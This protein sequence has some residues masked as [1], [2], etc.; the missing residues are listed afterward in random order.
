MKL[1]AKVSSNAFLIFGKRFGSLRH[2]LNLV[3]L[4]GSLALIVPFIFYPSLIYLYIMTGL[5]LFLGWHLVISIGGADMPVVISMLV[6]M[7]K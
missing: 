5:S 2:V 7:I 1:D 6:F 3:L 4:V